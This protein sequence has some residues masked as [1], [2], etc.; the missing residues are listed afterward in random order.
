MI[1]P[2][3]KYKLL[4]FDLEILQQRIAS[5]I[6]QFFRFCK[7]TCL[8]T[9]LK[10]K[11]SQPLVFYYICLFVCLAGGGWMFSSLFDCSSPFYFLLIVF[12]RLLIFFVL[13]LWLGGLEFNQSFHPSACRK[14]RLIKE[15]KLSYTTGLLHA[16]SS[17]MQWG[18]VVWTVG[19]WVVLVQIYTVPKADEFFFL[20]NQRH[21]WGEILSYSHIRKLDLPVIHS[22]PFSTWLSILFFFPLPYPHLLCLYCKHK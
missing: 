7:I 22:S 5:I 14:R 8:R 13:P 6:L 15:Y 21:P 18:V 10:I 3:S 4:N 20:K 16:W 1:P 12:W 17:C 11:I 2:T 9:L 19:Y